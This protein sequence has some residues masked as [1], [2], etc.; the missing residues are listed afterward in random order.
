MKYIDKRYQQLLKS[1]G[2]YN[3]P[4]DGI[5]GP[6]TKNGVILFQRANGLEADGIVGKKTIA[7]FESQI[8][9]I[10]DRQEEV[11]RPSPVK[12][13]Y[14]RW[15]KETT[16]SLMDFYGNV[17]ENQTRITLP[18]PMIIAW[19]KSKKI[20]SIVCHQKVAESLQRVLTR[21]SNEY[22]MDEINHHGFNLFGGCLN[23]RQ[24]RGGSRWSTHSWGIAIDIDP[25]RN[26]LRTPW[27]KAY[28]GR[29]ECRKFVQAFKDEGWYSLGLE[30]NYDPMHF[31]ACWR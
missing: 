29:P 13:S 4:V 17:G 19:D 23:V 20:N 15:P 31:Q 3:G 9:P 6:N 1:L 5:L 10:A 18:Y 12:Y 30:R 22:T 26:G 8:Q 24:I 2:F 25:A 11:D 27:N 16:R 7:G 14:S 28:L 21:V